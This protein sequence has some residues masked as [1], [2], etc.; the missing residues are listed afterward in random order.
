SARF[1]L[2]LW[3]LL[4]LTSA[5]AMTF[6]ISCRK[7]SF[8]VCPTRL[9]RF[10]PLSRR[11]CSQNKV[12]HTIRPTISELSDDQHLLAN[13]LAAAECIGIDLAPRPS[14]VLWLEDCTHCHGRRFLG[15][16]HNGLFFQRLPQASHPG[17]PL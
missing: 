3:L 13:R 8:R 14:L 6:P 16:S 2:L 7:S 5:S 11:S 4:L 9:R 10:T 17:L 1:S 12:Q 15:C